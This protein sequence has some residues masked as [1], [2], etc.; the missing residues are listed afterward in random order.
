LAAALRAVLAGVL[1]ADFFAG[2][3]LAGINWVGLSGSAGVADGG[4][5]Q[6]ACCGR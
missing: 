1:R 3:F 5:T 6:L 2:D 4:M